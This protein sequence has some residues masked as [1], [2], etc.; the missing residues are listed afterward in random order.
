MKSIFKALPI[1]ALVLVTGCASN[2]QLE[3]I[4]AKADRALSAAEQ[5]NAAAARAQSSA[6]RAMRAAESAQA[7]ANQANEKVDRAFKKAMEK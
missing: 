4:E 5:A 1:A 7:T 3:A 6:D 2:S